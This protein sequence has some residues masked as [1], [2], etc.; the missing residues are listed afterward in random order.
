MFLP[1]VSVLIVNA[2]MNEA[3]RLRR[4]HFPPRCLPTALFFL[5]PGVLHAVMPPLMVTLG[6]QMAVA[7]LV[8]AAGRRPI[9]HTGFTGMGDERAAALTYPDTETDFRCT[10]C[11]DHGRGCRSRVCREMEDEPRQERFRR[12]HD[13]YEHLLSGERPMVRAS[14]CGMI[15]LSTPAIWY[16]FILFSQRIAKSPQK[17]SPALQIPGP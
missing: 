14:S 7:G 5:I 13:R 17:G 16:A 6:R 8:D 2:A 4:D 9:H 11:R 3:P 10:C 12:S 15:R 1:A